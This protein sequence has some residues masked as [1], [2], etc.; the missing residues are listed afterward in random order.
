MKGQQVHPVKVHF[1]HDYPLGYISNATVVVEVSH[2]GN[3]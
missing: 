1:K 2:W 3:L